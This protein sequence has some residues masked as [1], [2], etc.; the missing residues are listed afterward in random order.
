[1]ATKATSM[2]SRFDSEPTQTLKQLHDTRQEPQRPRTPCF[3]YNFLDPDNP[4]SFL[5]AC[6]TY[7]PNSRPLFRCETPQQ[8][9]QML[10]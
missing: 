4:G 7:D 6:C 9:L 5:H 8:I 3:T 2:N 1:M 10:I